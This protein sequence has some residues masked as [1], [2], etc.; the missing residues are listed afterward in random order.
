MLHHFTTPLNNTTGLH[1]STKPV[2]YSPTLHHYTT[3]LNY[4]NALHYCMQTPL[5][6]TTEL[7]HY[8]TSVYQCT[9][10]LRYTTALHQNTFFFFYLLTAQ[11]SKLGCGGSI[12]KLDSVASL[13]TQPP[14]WN[15]TTRQTTPVWNPLYNY[16][17]FEPKWNWKSCILD[18]L[19]LS[20][21]ADSSTNTKLNK[22]YHILLLFF[23]S[24]V[25]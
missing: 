10:P 21:D 22:N 18:T 5:H 24:N 14:W 13:V 16:V 7:H 2:H 25:F 17:T 15:S 20:T 6:F 11:N 23:F 4:S 9:W 19:N 1:R 8:T 12:Y 3:P